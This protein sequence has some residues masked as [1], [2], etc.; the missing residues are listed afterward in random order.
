MRICLSLIDLAAPYV[1]VTE[2]KRENNMVDISW[3][4]G[5]AVSVDKNQLIWVEIDDETPL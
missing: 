2:I 4:V 1:H 5:G 3:R